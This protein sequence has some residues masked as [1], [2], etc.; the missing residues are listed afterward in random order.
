MCYFL[1][2][3][4]VTDL[5][6]IIFNS[7]HGNKDIDNGNDNSNH[8]VDLSYGIHVAIP[9]YQYILLYCITK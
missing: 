1:C 3:S 6:L 9:D 4:T 7:I 8:M 2:T 5:P